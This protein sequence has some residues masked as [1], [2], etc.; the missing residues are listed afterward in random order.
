MSYVLCYSP[1]HRVPDQFAFFPLFRLLLWLPLA[2]LPEFTVNFMKRIRS[3]SG[4]LLTLLKLIY[5]LFFIKG[6]ILRILFFKWQ[7]FHKDMIKAKIYKTF[8]TN[9]LFQNRYCHNFLGEIYENFS[10]WEG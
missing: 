7:L 6:S 5:K 8:P 9:T 2:L 4:L 1:N 3:H 10:I